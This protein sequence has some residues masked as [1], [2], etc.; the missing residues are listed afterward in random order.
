[1]T[2]KFKKYIKAFIM[3]FCFLWYISSGNLNAYI[4]VVQKVS[5]HEC[6]SVLLGGRFTVFTSPKAMYAI[7]VRSLMTIHFEDKKTKKIYEYIIYL[8]FVPQCNAVKMK[9][10]IKRILKYKYSVD[11]DKFRICLLK[12]E[13]FAIEDSVKFVT[14]D[15]S[16]DRDALLYSLS[17]S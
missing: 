3:I 1:M 11:I 10:L 7:G 15:I 12:I 5:K 4:E 2:I 6:K 9:K 14:V 8:G 17:I 16:N 13:N